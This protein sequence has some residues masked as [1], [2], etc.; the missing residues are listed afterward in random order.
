MTSTS[1]L[2]NLAL[3]L[4][5]IIWR[6]A[7]VSPDTVDIDLSRTPSE[8]P[9]LKQPTLPSTNRQ[10][11]RE[12][13]AIYYS[14][15]KFTI[16]ILDLKGAQ[17]VAFTSI[18]AKYATNEQGK[19]IF[20]I[21][22]QLHGVCHWLNFMDWLKTTHEAEC[23]FVSFPNI[24]TKGNGARICDGDRKYVAGTF[25]AMYIMK[26]RTWDQFHDWLNGDLDD[27]EVNN[28][29]TNLGIHIDAQT[30]TPPFPLLTNGQADEMCKLA[31]SR[32]VELE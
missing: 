23:K 9:G 8:C 12:S 15:N 19:S 14:E 20:D 28:I 2:L 32:S 29:M 22:T 30:L 17:Y 13:I 27:D 4:R 25:A 10:V 16:Q 24:P 31:L 7:L 3:E 18:V 5:D 6:F 21:K 11:R 1:R 26:S